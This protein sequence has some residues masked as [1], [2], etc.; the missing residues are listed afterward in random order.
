[1]KKVLQ[2]GKIFGNSMGVFLEN[3]SN[4]NLMKDK[5]LFS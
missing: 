1:M 5:A 4:R 2:G 3:I